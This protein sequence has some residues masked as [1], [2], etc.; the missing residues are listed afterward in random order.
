ME[1]IVDEHVDICGAEAVTCGNVLESDFKVAISKEYDE[2]TVQWDEEDREESK[3]VS[4][5]EK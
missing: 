4:G 5:K 3:E 2:E 1:T